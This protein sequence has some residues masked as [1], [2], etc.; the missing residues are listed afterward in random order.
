MKKLFF[1]LPF[2]F[3]PWQ[4]GC[5]EVTA[6]PLTDR[7]QAFFKNAGGSSNSTRAGVFQSQSAGYYTGGS[8]VGRIP[9]DNIQPFHIQMPGF[10]IGCGG[11]DAWFGGFSHISSEQLVNA[12]R[13]IGSS[14]ASYAFM[15]ALET[16][17]PEIYNVMNELQAI[18][19]KINDLNINT[20]EAAATALGGL[21]PQ[22]DATSKHLCQA[23][24]TSYGGLSDWTAARHKCG[25]GGERQR[26][27]DSPHQDLQ[28]TFKDEFNVVW[29]ALLKNPFLS[30][31]KRVAEMF[32]TI[33]GT[34][35]VKR[36]GDSYQTHHLR[37]AA[38][39]QSFM[40]TI[41]QG[42]TIRLYR[43]DTQEKCLIPTLSREEKMQ[44]KA[45]IPLVSS[46]LAAMVDKIFKDKRLTAEEVSFLNNTTLPIF[47]ILNVL[48]AYKKGHAPIEIESYAEIIALDIVHHFILNILD[49]VEDSVTQLRSA[50]MSDASIADYLENIKSVRGLI[51]QARGTAVEHMNAVLSMIHSVQLVEKQ[52]HVYLGTLSESDF[53]E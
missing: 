39:D 52:L 9:V 36:E 51:V 21:L 33:A 45:L 20:C 10:R 40:Q 34:L 47:K 25:S 6:S 35:I 8:F 30:R 48:T 16:I 14:M 1:I 27:L 31:D 28:S 17:S 38:L 49:L 41:L 4:E 26:I 44:S 5:M 22:S 13:Q 29:Q 42:G 2:M 53:Q 19:Q 3:S 32:M 7:L 37:S 24:G 15:I 18:A 11:I 12:L 43:C 46:T 50:Q 23:M